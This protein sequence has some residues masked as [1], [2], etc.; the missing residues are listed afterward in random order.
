[1]RLKRGTR[2]LKSHIQA[3]TGR[4]LS[5]TRRSAGLPYCI[6]STCQA[7]SS[8]DLEE[9]RNAVIE[10]LNLSTHSNTSIESKIHCLNTL[11]ILHTDATVSSKVMSMFIEPCYKLSI[12]SFVSSDWRIRNGALILFSGLT[13]RV[14]GSRALALDRSFD[15]LSKRETA[16]GTPAFFLV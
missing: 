15:S 9:L 11:K 5:F 7:L 2:F 3:I 13:N 1:M 14:F 8:F 10:I 6:L 12:E 16:S 4:K